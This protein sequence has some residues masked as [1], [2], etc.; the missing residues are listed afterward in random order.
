MS[1]LLRALRSFAESSWM[2][3]VTL[4]RSGTV[5]YLV[6]VPKAGDESAAK[7]V[8]YFWKSVG[9]L[10]D[11]IEFNASILFCPAEW[12]HQLN[13]W[14][15]AASDLALHGRVKHAFDPMATF[16]PGRFVGGI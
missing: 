13:I 4:I 10:R 7:Q 14:A 3:S 11:K 16:A 12:K 15:Y 9:S 8:A 1:T 6:L 2:P 5:L